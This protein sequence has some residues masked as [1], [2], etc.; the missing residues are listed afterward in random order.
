MPIHT[1]ERQRVYRQIAEQVSALIA[2]GEFGI[3]ERLPSERD[4]AALLGVS[5]PSVREALIALEIAGKVEVRVGTGIYVAAPRPV[6]VTDPETEGQGPFELLRARRLMEGEVA[7]VA[8]REATLEDVAAIR[9]AADEIHRLQLQNRSADTA[10]RDFH[11]GI[12]AATHNGALLSVVR[13]L[14]DRGRGTIWKRMELH[15]QTPDMRAASLS[16]HRAILE[17]IEVRDARGARA[18]MR[19]HLERVEREFDR[20][21]DLVKERDGAPLAPALAARKH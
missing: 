2:S 15:F 12:A 18:A 14:W 16:D 6:P 5:R 17:A 9:S 11:F 4:L 7:A 10:D 13:D 20:G 1:I 19:R 3:G 8:A 21:W